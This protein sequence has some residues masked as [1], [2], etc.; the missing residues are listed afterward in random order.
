[1]FCCGVFWFLW[2]LFHVSTYLKKNCMRRQT[3]EPCRNKTEWIICLFSFYVSYF[4]YFQYSVFSVLIPLCGVLFSCLCVVQIYY[5][6][7]VVLCWCVGFFL[8]IGTITGFTL[9][10]L[11]TLIQRIT[12]YRKR[13]SQRR[14]RGRDR[15][16]L[17]LPERTKNKRGRKE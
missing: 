5:V 3:P 2:W 16:K 1:M 4:V 17:P 11:G 13:T 6:I 14:E 7:S 12:K 9:F 8:A 10:S 15:A